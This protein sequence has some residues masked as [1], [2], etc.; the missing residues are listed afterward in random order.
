MEYR[1]KKAEEKQNKEKNKPSENVIGDSPGKS[2]IA[3]GSGLDATDEGSTGEEIALDVGKSLT[4]NGFPDARLHEHTV[5][6][7]R[8]NELE[9]TV[10]T[11]VHGMPYAR[12]FNYSTATIS[13]NGYQNSLEFSGNSSNY[14][15]KYEP[16]PWLR[17]IQKSASTSIVNNVI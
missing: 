16:S 2:I 1:K 17:G 4:V 9:E 5:K 14:D 13:D 15:R 10:S 3:N 12:K 11:Y 7:A 6:Q 8:K